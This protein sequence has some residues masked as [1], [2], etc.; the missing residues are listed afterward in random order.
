M[1]STQ[2][3]IFDKRL[4]DKS[5]DFDEAWNECSLVWINAVRAHCYCFI[6]FNFIQEIKEVQDDQCRNVL[7]KLCALF[8]LT[9]LLEDSTFHT[10]RDQLLLAREALQVALAEIRP[11]AVALVDSFDITDNVLNSVLGRFDGNV[12]EALYQSAKKSPLNQT[13]PFDGYKE[14]L[15]PHLDLEFLKRGNKSPN[16]KL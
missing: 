11:N 7:S 3:K 2:D 9:T 12:Y 10:P 5:G 16:S 6:M 15:Q 14:Y 4:E 1:L 8:G 13:D